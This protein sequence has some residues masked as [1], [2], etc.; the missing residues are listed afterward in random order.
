MHPLLCIHYLVNSAY[1]YKGGPSFAS[2]EALRG[3]GH[4]PVGSEW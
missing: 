3:A 2:L 4:V 1:G